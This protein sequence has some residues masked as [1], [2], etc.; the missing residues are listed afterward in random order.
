AADIVEINIDAFR[1]RGPQRLEYRAVLVIDRG[2][3]AEFRSQPVA[4]VLAAGDADDAAALYFSDLA[5][6]RPNRAG[7]GRDHD[8]LAGLRLADIEQSEI[9]GEPGDT[10][11]AEEM[12]HRLDLRHLAQML[13][14][15]DSVVL[16]AGI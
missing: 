6:D 10:V 3:E 15:D 9:G 12:R 2:I 8:G 5:D 1:C 7:G 14:R 13:C 16:P 11:D 4:L